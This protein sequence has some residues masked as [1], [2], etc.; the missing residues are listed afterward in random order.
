MLAP[1]I[2]AQGVLSI[3][4]LSALP[5]SEKRKFPSFYTRGITQMALQGLSDQAASVLFLPEP[6]PEKQASFLGKLASWRV[7]VPWRFPA[8]C[9][10][11][12]LEQAEL[13]I[14][15]SP[16]LSYATQEGC[17]S[18]PC[19]AQGVLLESRHS[20]LLPTPTIPQSSTRQEHRK[21]GQLGSRSYPFLSL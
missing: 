4:S 16:H 8:Q 2:A 1:E 21:F 12:P 13:K 14:R 10:T 11:G 20:R 18:C 3:G 17:L 9:R 15:Q 7:V 19:P 5:S 6:Q